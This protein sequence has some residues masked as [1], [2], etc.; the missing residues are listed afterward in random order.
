MSRRNTSE[1]AAYV[2]W[3][4]V[5]LAGADLEDVWGRSCAHELIVV[6]ALPTLRPP[7]LPFA[8]CAA[9][10]AVHGLSPFVPHMCVKVGRCTSRL[11]CALGAL[12]VRRA[13]Q[14]VSAGSLRRQGNAVAHRAPRRASIRV[15]SRRTWLC[16][17]VATVPLPPAG[18]RLLAASSSRYR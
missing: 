17:A 16:K 4:V 2:E 7:A 13:R 3:P 18:H 14:H 6:A 1:A 10:T 9:G 11:A 15:A 8:N 12:I 5:P